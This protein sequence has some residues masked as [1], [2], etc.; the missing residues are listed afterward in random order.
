LRSG[1]RSGGAL[2][3][4]RRRGQA[5]F[6]FRESLHRAGLEGL[7]VAV[8]P[9]LLLALA[10]VLGQLAAC[11]ADPLVHRVDLLAWRHDADVGDRPW[12]AGG[13]LART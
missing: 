9:G 13:G 5:L 12:R 4:L 6:Q 11:G 3:R 1:R 7:A 8:E 10:L 2:G